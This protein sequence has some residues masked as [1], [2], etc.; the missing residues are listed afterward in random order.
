MRIATTLIALVALAAPGAALAAPH[1]FEISVAPQTSLSTSDSVTAISDNAAHLSATARIGWEIIDG[2]D[3]YAGYRRIDAFHRLDNSGVEWNTDIY[4][5]LIG[6]R[7]RYR[8]VGDWFRLYGQLDIEANY[9]E[10]TMDLGDR[11]GSQGTWSGGLLPEVGL[12]ASFELDDT[13]QFVLRL[14]VGYALRLDHDFD[15]VAVG[16]PAPAERPVDLG[17]ANFS[18]LSVGFTAGVRF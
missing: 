5:A 6:A 13:V 4:S 18:A 1:P 7:F 17:P 8:L 11:H 14:G 16:T 12:E 10:L 15:A 2:L 3:L 9:A